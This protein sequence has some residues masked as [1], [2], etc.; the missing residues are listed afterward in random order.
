[1]IEIKS[2]SDLTRV[3]DHTLLKPETTRERFAA[4]VREGI[5]LGCGM[6]AINSLW[7]S[8]AKRLRQDSLIHIGAAIGFPL[9]QTTIAVKA[10]ETERA[11]A[12]GA[13][14][15]DYVIHIGALK[16]KDYDYLHTEM[17]TIVDICK[18]QGVICKVIFEN[19]LLTDEE[20]VAMCQIAREVRPDFIKTS[21]GFS[22]GGATFADVALMVKE[23]RGLVQV[24]AAGGIRDWPTCKKMLE[25]GATR[26]GTSSSKAIMEG[27]LQ[28]TL[29]K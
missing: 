4:Y 28:E 16:D 17:R 15:I 5:E 10:Y 19:C 25:L 12:E 27:Y 3:F 18:K 1:M 11:I 23:A 6:L 14:E 26:I 8:E 9:G 21:T 20:K 2:V 22:S 13:D 29:T 7:V 24:K